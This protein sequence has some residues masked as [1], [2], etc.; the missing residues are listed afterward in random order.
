MT[1]A[2]A[3]EMCEEMGAFMPILRTSDQRRYEIAA[4]V[5]ALNQKFMIDV[6]RYNTF[7]VIDNFCN[8]KNL[9]LKKFF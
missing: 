8:Q 4:R 7:G 1:Y 6:E 2:N 9:K 3:V 5:D